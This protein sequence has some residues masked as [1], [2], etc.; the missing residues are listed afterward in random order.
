L[1]LTGNWKKGFFPHKFNTPEHQ[2]Y[3]GTMPP[4][5]YYEPEA[6]KEDRLKVFEAWYAKESLQ[7]IEWNF[8]EQLL[9]YCRSD[10][11]LLARGLEKYD[12]LMRDLN[13]DI[14]PLTN[15]TLASY[16]L[17]VFRN[18]HLTP[19]CIVELTKD[20]FQFAKGA[21]H[22]GKTDVRILHREWSPDQV[23]QGTYGCYVDVQSMYP[24][25]Q[26]T[27]PMPCGVPVWKTFHEE[28]GIDMDFLESCIGI[29]E[30]DIKS[31]QYLHHPIIGGKDPKTQKYVFDLKPKERL[32]LTSVELQLALKHGYVVTRL[33]KALLFKDQQILFK[34]YIETFLKIKLE[35]SG[36]PK[37]AWETFAKQ[38]KEKLG[39]EL[40]PS[41]MIRNEGLRTMAKLMLNSLWGKLGQDPNLPHNVFIDNETEYK[42]LLQ[43]EY[44]GE[45]SIT[46]SMEVTQNKSLIS[47]KDSEGTL[48][49]QN[50]N[51]VTA[52]FVAAYG[53]I[54]LWET[55]H[56]LGER[57]LYHDT[58]SVVYEHSRDGPK[59]TIGY[60]LGEWEDELEENDC[61]TSFVALGPKTYSYVTRMGKE[62]LKCK[63][64]SLNV[65]NRKSINHDKMIEILKDSKTHADSCLVLSDRKFKWDR[66][67][68]QYW[69]YLQSKTMRFTADKNEIDW[70]TYTTTPFQ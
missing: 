46:Q 52:A 35:A 40:D 45:I 20:E 67:N 38:H 44:R 17:T 12:E 23:A 48:D 5:E 49:L 27:R 22:G 19:N 51:V 16:A 31:T 25:V 7:A 62:S 14:S 34:S 70:E 61:I 4:K 69:S 15:V 57:V 50:K 39:I 68:G 9:S 29:I 64:F 28:D 32:I 1:G 58:D 36:V 33:Y 63:G 43:K 65:G 26:Y 30:C 6:M 10:T 24:F 56:F 13:R 41:K 21:L 42:D 11:L 55:L 53:R 47:Y 66:T 3:I 37:V 54:H 59:V 8:Q 60:M 18:L 2:E